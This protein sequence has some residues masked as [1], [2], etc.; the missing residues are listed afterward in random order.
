MAE[1]DLD[2]IL[3]RR[4]GQALWGVLTVGLLFRVAYLIAQP[5]S[6]PTCFSPMLDGAYYLDWARG[7]AGEGGGFDGAYYLGP[8][9]AYLLAGFLA[10]FGEKLLL[11]Y[12]VQH[13]LVLLA[14]G[15]IALHVRS[16]VGSTAA[17][18]G[19]L[20]F[21]LHHPLIFFAS[22]PLG[23][24][25][26][27]A[28][29]AGSLLLI[30][31][32]STGGTGGAG[33]LAGLS[34]LARPNILLVAACWVAGL[35]MRR[36]LRLAVALSIGLALALVPVAIRN[37]SASGHLVPISSNAGITAYHGNGPGAVGV[38]VHPEGFVGGLEEQREEAT[39]I[40]SARSGTDLHPVEADRWWGRQALATRLDRPGE[41]VL[42][43]LRRG[44]LLLDNHEHGLD[45]AP[46]LDGNPFRA[47]L[48]LA[49]RELALV[50][51]GLLLGL[52]VAGTILRGFRGSGGW[53]VW[54]TLAALAMTP[55]LFYVSS[56]YRL[57]MTALLTV[58]AGAGIAALLAPAVPSK[59]KLVAAIAG[60]LCLLLSFAVPSGSLRV[61]A[62]ASSRA[63]LAGAHKARGDLVAAERE[64]RAA[65]A[66]DPRSLKA[67]FNLGVILEAAGRGPEAEASY[68]EALLL[69]QDHPAVAGNL[70]GLLI[71]RGGHVEAI[72]I[73]RRA[74]R[75]H[76]S[77]EP[78]WTN[79][80]VA[81][82]IAG[83]SEA[84]REAVDEAG[85][86]GVRIDPGL[87]D[88]ARRALGTG[89]GEQP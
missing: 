2:A 83:E 73:L 38:F 69:D 76:P 29:L 52:A 71:L 79:L 8:L 67:H 18:A 11:L 84:A 28:L 58:P 59:R 89:D 82:V 88:H 36:R 39:R 60:G 40:A 25:V 77:N 37:F 47:T 63:N 32:S 17:L 87:V 19:A 68:R 81:L 66:L 42:L 41:S 74:L 12:L 57:P 44:A 27:L 48:R 35:A 9:F 14:A 65:I 46:A 31:R 51:F 15:M 75:S 1:R 34:A 5:M 13:L 85:K 70:S 22:R 4:F 86:A 7:M 43:L 23:E 53:Y 64:A 56:R 30:G 20:L 3:G 26:A 55:L 50:P 21:V 33:L 80:V 10:L 54:S 72:S 6:D 45:Y 78:C 24:P 61:T 49:G 62:E 16:I